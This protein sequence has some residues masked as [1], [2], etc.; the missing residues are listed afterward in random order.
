M[1]G[2][3]YL[4]IAPPGRNLA[5]LLALPGPGWMRDGLVQSICEPEGPATAMAGCGLLSGRARALA[6]GERHRFA[7]GTASVAGRHS[8]ARARRPHVFRGLD[9]CPV[10]CPACDM[11]A[12]YGVG[13]DRGGFAGDGIVGAAGGCHG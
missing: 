2:G 6:G 9:V 13:A 7:P 8:V 3:L 11:S 12:L 10:R 4:F 5:S 1:V